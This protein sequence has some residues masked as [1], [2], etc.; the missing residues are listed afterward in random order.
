[1]EDLA[2]DHFGAFISSGS[3]TE[4]M[5]E[6]MEQL[7]ESAEK[8]AGALP[9]LSAACQEF[10]RRVRGIS[11]SRKVNHKTL[12][13][14]AQLL[15][16]LELAQLM[17]A[18]V[19][20]HH[21]DEA[22]D[23]QSHAL[24]MANQH[25]DI[26][27]IRLVAEEIKASTIAMQ[28]QL[29]QSLSGAITLPGCLRIIGYLKRLGIYSDWE[30][31][32]VYLQCRGQYMNESLA[33]VPTNNHY[34]FL[35]KIT[36]VTRSQLSEITTQYRAIFDQEEDIYSKLAASNKSA[37]TVD[38]GEDASS[39]LQG[40]LYHH[41]DV[42]VRTLESKLPLITDGTSISNLLSQCM[43]FGLSM[44]RLGADFRHVL[45]PIFEATILHM[46]QT[47]LSLALEVFTMQLKRYRP[48]VLLSTSVPATTD[49][50]KPANLPLTPPLSLMDHMPLAHLTNCLIGT[51]NELRKCCPYSLA[52]Q[53]ATAFEATLFE[54]IERLAGYR[55]QM[56]GDS[57][58]DK[59]AFLA[60][61][62]AYSEDFLPFFLA[63]YDSLWKSQKR[64][65][66][67]PAL[68]TRLALL[69]Q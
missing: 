26:P 10:C 23:I 7:A 59:K 55:S 40:W 11:K 51:L 54:S 9:Q 45:S 60:L 37:T 47:Q 27:V 61:C 41:I 1:M 24:R 44:G 29:H 20:N 62:K 25:Q 58:Q 21:Y 52:T 56:E 35:S 18:C 5:R 31:R 43:Y 30:L 4:S 65:L 33:V 49:A 64:I 50:E 36:D 12:R 48:L 3:C 16:I 32:I 42:F 17:D 8:V 69:T 53:L 6:E 67:E 66:N 57:E 19:Q 63:S 14:H 2:F 34:N 38:S 39:I 68:R 13:Q 46:V 28:I 15:E 22:L